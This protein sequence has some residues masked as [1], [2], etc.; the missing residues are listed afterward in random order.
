MCCAAIAP[1]A[2]A[3]AEARLRWKGWV[4][5]RAQLC[6]PPHCTHHYSRQRP[7][8]N[9]SP[10]LDL[11]ISFLPRGTQPPP[12]HAAPGGDRNGV[13]ERETYRAGED[14]P[15]AKDRDD[16]DPVCVL[17]LKAAERAATF[18]V[19]VL[20]AQILHTGREWCALSTCL[21]TVQLSLLA[22]YQRVRSARSTLQCKNRKN[23]AKSNKKSAKFIKRTATAQLD[24]PTVGCERLLHQCPSELCLLQEA[25]TKGSDCQLLTRA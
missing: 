25:T 14:N 22:N 18:A 16:V 15:E 7:A 5:T 4:A 19:E 24:A 23:V 11:I 9:L 3:S 17:V 12:P 6:R 8:H 2:R 20:A 21:D 1:A 10:L 13:D